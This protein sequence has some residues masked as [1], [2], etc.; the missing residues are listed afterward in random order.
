GTDFLERMNLR[1]DLQLLPAPD[2]DN[3][4]NAYAV[5]EDIDE[6]QTFLDLVRGDGTF[7]LQVP[8]GKY[9]VKLSI[10]GKNDLSDCDKTVVLQENTVVLEGQRETLQLR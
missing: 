10:C 3:R 4:L 1:D 8:P 7:E 6:T 2:Y 9:N 5:A